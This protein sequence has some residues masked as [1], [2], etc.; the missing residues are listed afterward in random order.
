MAELILAEEQAQVF[1]RAM[2]KAIQVRD[3]TGKLLAEIA[4]ECNLEFLAE[5]KRRAA[6]PGPWFSSSQVQARLKALQEEWE[7]TGGFDETHMHAFL[8]PLDQTDPGHY[9]YE[10]NGLL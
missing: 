7:H 6:S 1:R 9:R 4:P 10:R 8:E 3:P 2:A 5:L